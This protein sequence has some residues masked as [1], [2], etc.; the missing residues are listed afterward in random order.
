M[1][2]TIAPALT[3]HRVTPADAGRMRALRL[4]MLAAER[5]T[6]LFSRQLVLGDNVDLEHVKADEPVKVSSTV[7]QKF[8]SWGVSCSMQ[9]VTSRSS[10]AGM[11]L[12][13]AWA[14]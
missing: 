10:Q 14:V 1:T 11:A 12:R 2:S 9:M 8:V 4:E 7:W 3:V 13:K 6:G 5:P